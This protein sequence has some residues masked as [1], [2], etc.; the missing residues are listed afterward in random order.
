MEI[1]LE[2]IEIEERDRGAAI[3]AADKVRNTLINERRDL[4]IKM[5]AHRRPRTGELSKLHELQQN[6]ELI[7]AIIDA[8]QE[9]A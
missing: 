7:E 9:G 6:I 2:D 3:E 8:E 4:L 5:V 1:D